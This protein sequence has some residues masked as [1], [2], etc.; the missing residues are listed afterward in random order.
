MH[1]ISPP[2]RPESLAAEGQGGLGHHHQ[3]CAERR[4]PRPAI[5]GAAAAPLALGGITPPACPRPGRRSRL[6]TGRRQRLWSLQAAAK[7]MGQAFSCCA[8]PGQRAERQEKAPGER[9]PRA[10]CRLGAAARGPPLPPPPPPPPPSPPSRRCPCPSVSAPALACLAD[11]EAAESWE[12]AAAAAEA[13]APPGPV[14]S[15]VSALSTSSRHPLEAGSSL[16][17]PAAGFRHTSDLRVGVLEV[18]GQGG[19]GRRGRRGGS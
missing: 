16:G 15:R 5:G 3:P 7:R 19:G 9:S 18:R 17:P 4:V 2:V 11:E 1:S 6:C 10:A 14:H 8:R 12:A 13:S